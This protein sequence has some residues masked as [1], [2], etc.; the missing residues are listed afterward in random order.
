MKSCGA[1]KQSINPFFIRKD[2]H[3]SEL[4]FSDMKLGDDKLKM[5]VMFLPKDCDHIDLSGNNLNYQCIE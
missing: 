1:K 5:L 2:E 3:D 4:D